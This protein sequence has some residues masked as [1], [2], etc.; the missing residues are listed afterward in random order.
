MAQTPPPPFTSVLHILADRAEWNQ[1]EQYLQTL[2][3]SS[4]SAHKLLLT[5]EGAHG[6]TPLMISCARGAPPNIIRALLQSCPHSVRV[7]DMSGSY[8]LHFF[9]TWKVGVG[10]EAEQQDRFELNKVL[11]LLLEAGPEVLNLHD[12]WGQTPLHCIFDNILI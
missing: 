7:A 6:L 1:L 4:E 8:P 9:C 11:Q 2:Q 5:C 3:T 12:Q 10:E